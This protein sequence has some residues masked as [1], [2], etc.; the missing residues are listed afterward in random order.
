MTSTYIDA[1]IAVAIDAGLDVAD[2]FAVVVIVDLILFFVVA[3]DDAVVAVATVFV[4]VT[5]FLV[6]VTAV[7]V[8][9]VGFEAAKVDNRSCFCRSKLLPHLM[10]LL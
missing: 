4:T 6:A 2:I 7:V 8:V 10:K 1:A 5:L 3:N 9:V